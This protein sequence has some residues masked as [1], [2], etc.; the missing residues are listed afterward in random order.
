MDYTQAEL[1]ARIFPS[2]DI[3][4]MDLMYDDWVIDTS[5]DCETEDSEPYEDESW[6]DANALE[7]AG[8]GTDEDYG[9]CDDGD[10]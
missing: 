6:M 1:E 2:V 10:W 3:D 5:S 7:S 9:G 8:F 4:P